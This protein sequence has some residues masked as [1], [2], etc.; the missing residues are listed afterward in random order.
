MRILRKTTLF[1]KL[2][3]KL[4]VS[5][6]PEQ[7]DKP[8]GK[9]VLVLSP[10]CD[11]AVFGCGGTLYKHFKAGDKVSIL[12]LKVMNK[13][14]EDEARA[15]AEILGISK[16]I[17]CESDV[18]NAEK[19]TDVLNKLMPEIIYTPHP[20]D[21]HPDHYQT[22]LILANV[23]S[24]LKITPILLCYEIWTPII[25]NVVIDISECIEYKK[26]AIDCFVSQNKTLD[27]TN[28]IIGLNQYRSLSLKQG[29]SFAECFIRVNKKELTS[30]LKVV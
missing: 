8:D 2:Y 24:K 6:Y 15:T 17:F 18:N 5:P 4:Y 19:I 12:Y 11:D 16:Q 9:V 14:M 3:S 20:M 25:P 23:I 27:Y 29:G 26:L 22:S 28:G 30:L 13:V 1:H 10:H 7:I 21:N